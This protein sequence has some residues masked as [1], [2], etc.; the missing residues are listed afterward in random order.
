[1]FKYLII[2]LVAR[3]EIKEDGG[4]VDLYIKDSIESK[5]PQDLNKIDQSIEHL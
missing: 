5:V 2:V 4:G 3:T 1:M